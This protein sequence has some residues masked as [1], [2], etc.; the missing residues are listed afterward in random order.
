MSHHLVTIYGQYHFLCFGNLQNFP[1]V[2]LRAAGPRP[3]KA[4]RVLLPRP[5]RR[6]H[7]N[8]VGAAST[9]SSLF[10]TFAL[11]GYPSEKAKPRSK[12]SGFVVGLP[13]F[14]PR[15]T[16]PKSV[17]LPLYYRPIRLKRSAKIRSD[18]RCSKRICPSGQ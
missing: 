5:L 18:G 16:E 10:V 7:L 2:T 17:V 14:E 13:G 1:T 12:A 6:I 3:A 4:V 11:L 9:C 8:F 15:Q